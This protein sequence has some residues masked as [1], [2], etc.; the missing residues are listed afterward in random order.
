MRQAG[1]LA[2]AGLYALEHHV[3]G[4]REDNRRALDFGRAIASM[5]GATL[6]LETVR[7][8]IVVFQ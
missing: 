5:P 8:N 6:A 3:S 7:S 4:L 2:A 1:V